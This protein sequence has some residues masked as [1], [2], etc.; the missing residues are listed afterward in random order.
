[1]R[2]SGIR[3]QGRGILLD[4]EGTTSSISFVHDVMFPY[5]R[6]RL[7]SYL[8]TTWD[9]AATREACDQ[10]AR[11]AGAA[12]LASWLDGGAGQGSDPQQAIAAEVRRLMDGDVKATGLKALQGLIWDAGFKSGQLR[13]HVY[14][15]VLPAIAAWRA[16]GIDVRIYSSGSIAAQKLFFGH[17]DGAGDCLHLFSGHYDTTSG[18]KREAASYTRIANDWGLAPADI[19]FISDLAAELTAAH[20]AGLAVASSVRPGNAPLPDDWNLPTLQ[21][22]T[23]VEVVA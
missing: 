13:A 14:P 23:E 7:E 18:S 10:I 1:V 9:T 3:F 5:V 2:P 11:D 16:R 8:A 19:L 22:F 12:D 20:A 17:I 15:D 21:A 4:I 6:E